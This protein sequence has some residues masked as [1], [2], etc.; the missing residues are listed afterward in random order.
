MTTEHLKIT[1]RLKKKNSAKNSKTKEA[2]SQMKVKTFQ[3][4]Q[5]LREV[6]TTRNA[7]KSSLVEGN[8]NSNLYIQKQMKSIRNNK[9][10]S[11]YKRLYIFS[12][13]K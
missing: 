3:D 1:K 6:A 12:F 7:K 8:D 10:L 11:K 2:P 4:K 13:L 5:K 9:Y